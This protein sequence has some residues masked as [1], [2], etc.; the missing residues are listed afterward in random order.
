RLNDRPG[1]IAGFRQTIADYSNTYYGREAK[2]QL[3]AWKTPGTVVDAAYRRAD[4]V[5][6]L[7]PGTVPSNA[8]LI[9]GL[10]AAGLYDDALSELR[11][12]ERD[13]GPTP[14]VEA[15]MAYAW[16]RKG[17]L[18]SGIQTMRRAYPQFLEDGGE[19]LP[20]DVLNVIFP[21]AYFDLIRK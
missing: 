11:L 7:I 9:R 16:N 6:T 17:D 5:A 15:T 3:D 14:L 8:A 20:P 4:P 12:L 18:R 2:R 1:A 19:T 10:L 21:V 13:L